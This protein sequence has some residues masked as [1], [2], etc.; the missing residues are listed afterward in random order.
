MQFSTTQAS[1]TELASSCIVVSIDDKGN[2]S[3]AAEAINTSAEQYLTDIFDSG[4][5]NGKTGETLKLIKV[6]GMSAQRLILVGSGKVDENGISAKN[7]IKI[8]DAAAAAIKKSGALQASLFLQDI[9]VANKDNAW[10]AEQAAIACENALYLFDQTKSKPEH[11]AE[12]YSDAIEAV[13]W[14]CEN[15]ESESMQAALEKG[16]AVAHGVKIGRAHV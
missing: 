12:D 9:P 5:F 1:A 10:K 15:A 6:P 11:E 4:D 13:L 7:Y 8:A 3:N 16:Q 14:A 2:L